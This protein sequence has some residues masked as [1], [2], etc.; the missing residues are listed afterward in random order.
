MNTNACVFVC[1]LVHVC[2]HVCVCSRACI[3]A[4]A[5]VCV[6]ARTRARM[7]VMIVGFF[8]VCFV[9]CCRF[10]KQ[11]LKTKIQVSTSIHC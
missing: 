11:K 2:V 5:R 8:P 1:G 9:A 4:R 6:C 3:H 7:T 10:I